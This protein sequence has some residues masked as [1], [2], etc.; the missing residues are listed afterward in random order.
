ML[1]IKDGIGK[2]RSWR[3]DFCDFPFDDPDGFLG[4]F[5][6]VANGNAISLLDEF[7]Q[8]AIY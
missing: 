4:I 2:N 3:Q 8:V 6:L 5:H 7:G 1:V